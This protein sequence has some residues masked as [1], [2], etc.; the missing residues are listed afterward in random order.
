MKSYA[1]AVNI[2]DSQTPAPKKLAIKATKQQKEK[3][4]DQDQHTSLPRQ[5]SQ[6]VFLGV[7]SLSDSRDQLKPR[8]PNLAIRSQYSQIGDG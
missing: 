1:K 2:A 4:E 3:L 8:F 6:S 5:Y 7:I